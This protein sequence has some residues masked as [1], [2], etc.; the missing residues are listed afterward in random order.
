MRTALRRRGFRPHFH[1]ELLICVVERGSCEI[2]I[3]ERSSIDRGG[4]ISFVNP[5]VVHD[6]RAGSSLVEYRTAYVEPAFALSALGVAAHEWDRYQLALRGGESPRLM[7]AF[8]EAHRASELDRPGVARSE[9]EQLIRE[10][11]E[12]WAELRRVVPVDP[13]DGLAK[14]RRR[15]EVVGERSPGIEELA[16][17]A[18]LSAHYFS[19]AFRRRYGLPP[20]RWLLQQRIDRAKRLLAGRLPLAEIALELGFVDQ[21]HFGACFRAIVGVSPGRYR[22]FARPDPHHAR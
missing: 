17:V 4:R 15:L 11:L 7:A 3:G 14:A 8:L 18:G 12:Y 21:S 10:I 13:H 22:A 20:H 16:R 2:R 9:L 6:G 5:G 1:R 19:R